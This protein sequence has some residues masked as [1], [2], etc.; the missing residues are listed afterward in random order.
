MMLEYVGHVVDILCFVI[1]FFG[2]KMKRRDMSPYSRPVAFVIS[3]VAHEYVTDL[4]P[5]RCRSPRDELAHD[6]R[7]RDK[8][9]VYIDSL[10]RDDAVRFVHLADD[11]RLPVGYMGHEEKKRRRYYAEVSLPLQG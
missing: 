6:R 10:L 7:P 4:S 11:L 3:L 2:N 8:L 9:R 1:T 5:Y